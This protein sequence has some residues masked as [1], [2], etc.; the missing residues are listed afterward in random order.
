MRALVT[1]GAG[2]VGHHLIE[3]ILKTTDW[4]VVSLDRLDTSGNLNRLADMPIWEREKRRI[5]VV[6]HDLRA[7]PN[8]QVRAQ[9]GPVHLIFH[10]AG[11]SHVDRSIA[12]PPS[13]VLDNVLG[14][15]HV[16]ELARS[17]DGLDR[18]LYF[19]TDEVF[20][21]APP[22][23]R[24]KEW[25]RYHS[26]NPY[27]ATK[28]GGE[29]LCLAYANTYKVPVVISHSMNIFGERQHPE[30]FIPSTIR[31]V[32]DG[33]T[34]TIHADRTRRIPGSRHYIHARNVADAAL[35]LMEHGLSGEKYNVVGEREVNNLELATFIAKTVGKPL[36][37]DLVD[38][39]SSRPGH[40]LR[41]AL[42][43]DKMQGMGWKVPV[44]FESSLE[45]TIRW[46]LKHPEWLAGG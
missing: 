31:R 3:H 33:R 27:A 20:G 7:M 11:A 30:K 4:E 40:D 18:M 22:G 24:F 12:D 42:C 19:G 16:L 23:V 34:V 6:F 29:E 41:Y 45:K 26:G 32:C 44:S 8:G 46:T 9:I 13:F 17:V 36:S 28:A 21:P 1:G 35:F 14:T 37:Y 38:F 25:D 10:L 15:C 39:H 43:G 5:R 2:F